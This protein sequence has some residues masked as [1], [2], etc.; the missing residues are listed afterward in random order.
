VYFWCCQL[1]WASILSVN[2]RCGEINVVSNCSLAVGDTTVWVTRMLLVLGES[3]DLWCHF[4]AVSG[5]SLYALTRVIMLQFRHLLPLSTV[6]L[7]WI[8]FSLYYLACVLSVLCFVQVGLWLTK[9][10]MTDWLAD[11][12]IDWLIDS[13]SAITDYTRRRKD[14]KMPAICVTVSVCKQYKAKSNQRTGTDFFLS[15][16]TFKK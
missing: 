6:P 5:F 11:W 8:Y 14:C 1:W 3:A 13:D 16:V 12:L 15:E 9:W 7:K 2:L 4:L 10:L